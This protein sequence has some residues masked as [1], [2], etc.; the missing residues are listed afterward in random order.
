M[1][2]RVVILVPVPQY[3]LE[4]LPDLQ[5][6]VLLNPQ[7]IVLAEEVLE[8]S[9][10]VLVFPRIKL[11]FLFAVKILYLEEQVKEAVVALYFIE[12]NSQ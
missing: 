10:N 11:G 6:K 9:E 5:L 12:V 3:A 8:L 1:Q 2:R 4:Q 7:V